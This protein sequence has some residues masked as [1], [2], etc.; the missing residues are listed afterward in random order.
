MSATTHFLHTVSGVG[1]ILAAAPLEGQQSVES[2]SLWS[3][4]VKPL[5]A[6]LGAFLVVAGIFRIAT[7]VLGGRAQ[8]AMKTGVLT[9]IA[10]AILFNISLV[11]RII[12]VAGTAVT[13]LIDS[14]GS[15]IGGGS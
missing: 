12:G 8:G 14:I 5:A 13:A 10:G 11:F 3:N 7:Q 4:V 1:D 6:G 15:L 2:T 9:V